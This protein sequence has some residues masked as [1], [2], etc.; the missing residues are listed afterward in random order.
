ML[1]TVSCEDYLRECMRL[2]P[3]EALPTFFPELICLLPDILKQEVRTGCNTVPRYCFGI[4]S[5]L[6]LFAGSGPRISTIGSGSDR[7]RNK[8]KAFKTK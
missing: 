1:G 3:R 2:A 4:T 6:G 5:V 8:K 7:I